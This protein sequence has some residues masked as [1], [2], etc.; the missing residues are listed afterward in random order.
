MIVIIMTFC[1]L[2]FLGINKFNMLAFLMTFIWGV[3]DAYVNIHCFEILG[4]EFDNNSE[5]F[6]IFNLA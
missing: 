3:Q 5:P 2:G 1:T 4:F 6:S